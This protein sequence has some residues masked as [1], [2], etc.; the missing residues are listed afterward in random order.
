MSNLLYIITGYIFPF[1]ARVGPGLFRYL[2]LV[3]NPL[4]PWSGF[5]LTKMLS[6]ETRTPLSMSDGHRR[7]VQ[8][9]A[10]LPAS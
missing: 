2:L 5:S 8:E 6:K 4:L 1:L 3:K 9:P 10:A 7:Q